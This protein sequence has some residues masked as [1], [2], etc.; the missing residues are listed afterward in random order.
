MSTNISLTPELELYAKGQVESGMYGSISE[1]VR[2]AIRAH[3]ERN[4]ERE[5]YLQQMHKDLAKAADEIDQ[6]KTFPYDPN[7]ILR[8]SLKKK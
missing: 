8:K 7:E 2:D 3:R 5:I 6:N 4:I 1:F